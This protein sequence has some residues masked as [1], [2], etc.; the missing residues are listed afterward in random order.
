M[1]TLIHCFYL[2]NQNNNKIFCLIFLVLSNIAAEAA[3]HAITE[4][5]GL[6][7]FYCW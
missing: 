4:K 6:Y 3:F 1:S 5:N 7:S 2:E